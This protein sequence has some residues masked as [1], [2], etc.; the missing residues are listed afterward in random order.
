MIV[1]K[2]RNGKLVTVLNDGIMVDRLVGVDVLLD[3]RILER[4]GNLKAV[5][6][7]VKK[8]LDFEGATPD[9]ALPFLSGE[10]LFCKFL[11]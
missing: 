3:D 9:F 11:A 8:G 4:E 5:D 10:I 6:I 1:R 7:M 2:G